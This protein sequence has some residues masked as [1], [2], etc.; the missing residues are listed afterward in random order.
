MRPP[1]SSV[2]RNSVARV[3]VI[4]DEPAIRRFLRTGLNSFGYD[5]EEA[6]TGADALRQAVIAPSDLIV[7]DLGLPD[8]D[9]LDVIRRLR[10]WCKAPI[11]V[12]SVR[13]AET[14]K[15]RALDAGAD[16]FITKPFSMAEL[17]ARMRA[18]MRRMANEQAG[19]PV[20][21]CGGIAIDLSSRIVTVDGREIHLSPKEYDLLTLLTR[22]HGK[23][24]THRQIMTEIWGYAGDPQNL[25]VLVG[26]VRR[27][28]EADPAVP[29]LI[30]AEPGIGYRLSEG[31]A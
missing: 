19:S 25:R 21:Q 29:R 15:V 9:G 26:Q 2:A 23:I 10:D 30:L 6:V 28:V 31:T 18:T 14:E 16:D 20:L 12:L 1:N 8:M 24:M 4:D 13:D 22:N 3:L 5:V 17:M 7:L 27:K 11:I